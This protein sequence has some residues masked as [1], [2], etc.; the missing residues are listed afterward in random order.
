VATERIR[1]LYNKAVFEEVL[2]RDGRIAEALDTESLTAGDG[3]RTRGIQLGRNGM[4]FEIRLAKTGDW[5]ALFAVLAADSDLY[6]TR[7]IK[8]PQGVP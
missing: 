1:K 7:A 4:V 3:A 2:V 5:S 6:V 8:M